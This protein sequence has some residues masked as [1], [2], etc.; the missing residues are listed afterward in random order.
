MKII[1]DV[2]RFSAKRR[3]YALVSVLLVLLLAACAGT[4]VKDSHEAKP[5]TQTANAIQQMDAADDE[6]DEAENSLETKK[7]QSVFSTEGKKTG[8]VSKGIVVE[9]QNEFLGLTIVKLSKWGVRMDSPSISVIL[10]PGKDAMA[11]NSQNGSCLKLSSKSA[12]FMSGA[13]GDKNK[14]AGDLK[15]RKLGNEVICGK[16]CVHYRLS[17]LLK[18]AKTNKVYDSWAEDV[19]TTKDLNVPPLIIKEC[20]KLT[21]LPPDLGFPVKIVRFKNR[22]GE[23]GAEEV[24]ELLRK[25]IVD[26]KRQ[27]QVIGTVSFSPQELDKG[28]F[29]YLQGFK[30]AE[31]EMQFMMSSDDSALADMDSGDQKPT[32]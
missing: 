31:D 7:T 11:Y 4:V 25:D 19:W 14:G 3:A 26:K 32:R 13:V 9:Q 8:D 30:A 5:E 17:K 27:R 21:L 2:Y 15:T 24:E 10:N 1:D 23:H 6:S 28:E 20:A 18:D 29:Q 16:P 12:A 22:N